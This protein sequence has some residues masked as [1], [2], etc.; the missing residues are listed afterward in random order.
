MNQ[1][2]LNNFQKPH[3]FGSCRVH[4][5]HTVLNPCSYNCPLHCMSRRRHSVSNCTIP[6]ACIVS[7]FVAAIQGERE[8]GNR[9]LKLLTHLSKR[10]PTGSKTSR[11]RWRMMASA[12]VLWNNE[13]QSLSTVVLA[14]KRELLTSSL[15]IY[16]FSTDF[17]LA[18]VLAKTSLDQAL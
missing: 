8:V 18:S 1:L 6:Q 17:R 5:I 12:V 7:L 11:Y 2:F 13:R 3:L 14:M 4:V 10:T 15:A 16:N 9:E